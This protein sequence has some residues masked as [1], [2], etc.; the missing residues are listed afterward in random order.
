MSDTNTRFIPGHWI[1]SVIFNLVADPYLGELS[2]WKPLNM[3]VC[4]SSSL[5]SPMYWSHVVE[6]IALLAVLLVGFRDVQ[7]FRIV[8]CCALKKRY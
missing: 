1:V 8:G 5:L 7:D 2:H 3:H 6:I 4:S